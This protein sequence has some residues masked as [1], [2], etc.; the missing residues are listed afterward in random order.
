MTFGLKRFGRCR[1]HARQEKG[2]LNDLE[3]LEGDFLTKEPITI[4]LVGAGGYGNFYVDLLLDAKTRDFRVIGV[5][6]PNPA[7]C[8]RL[9]EL[10]GKNV[11]LYNSL[12]EF[13]L[14][15]RADLAIISSPIQFH[16]RQIITAVTAGSHVL[17]EK[18]LCA[19]VEEGKAII[20]ARKKTGKLVT[21]GYQWS[22]SAAI[23]GLKKE[24]SSGRLG[25]AQRLKTMVLWPRD[26]AYYRRNGWAGRIKDAQGRWVLDSVVN[27]ATAHFLHNMF[28][29][30]GQDFGKSAFPA[31]V[32]AELYRANPIE[33]YDTAALRIRTADGIELM[34]YATHA[35]LEEQNPEFSFEFENAVVNYDQNQG[36][37][38]VATFKSGET[39][40]YGDPFAGEE[41]KLWATITALKEGKA[42]PCGPEAALAQVICVN[43]IQ[44][45]GEI[46]PF[47]AELINYHTDGQ[48]KKTGV[49]VKGLTQDLIGA[50]EEWKLPSEQGAAWAR[51]GK[52]KHFLV[53]LI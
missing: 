15:H 53:D 45:T 36:N 3:R 21:V 16:A 7:G 51:P 46:T 44:E 25:R 28:F 33:N 42:V 29:I 19:T 22:F 6:E 47:P 14:Q 27:N 48:G 49:Y 5:V 32:T 40:V 39:R 38:I 24:I 35:T 37:N 11:P 26:F 1:A 30:L 50:Y 2:F 13:Y 43:G 17:C 23:Q 10:L 4:L 18:P 8:L 20:E 9:K 34:Y 52:T 12:D 31:V 41:N